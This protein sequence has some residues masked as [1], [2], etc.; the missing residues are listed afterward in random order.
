MH[1]P[2]AH[3]AHAAHYP[4]QRS[5]ATVPPRA[6][7][8]RRPARDQRGVSLIEVL[9][10]AVVL[11]IGLLGLAGLQLRG[12]QVNQGSAMRAQA[13]ILAEDLADRMR[14]DYAA[15]QSGSF[16]G[17]YSA[18]NIATAS[19]VPSLVDWLKG[20][21]A[22]PAGT[23]SASP[24]SGNVLPCVQIQRLAGA[25]AP[26][27]VRIDVY[28]YDKRAV[29]AANPL[30]ANPGITASGTTPPSIGTYTTIADL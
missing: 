30:A 18:A 13:G 22:L 12:M 3:A 5:A 11:A 14:S 24:C 23:D 16:I 17:S 20:L 26:I 6:A 7:A 29:G 4:A 10:A 27:P 28:W 8:G 2:A 21:G 1:T 9:V 19:P 15:T 25:T